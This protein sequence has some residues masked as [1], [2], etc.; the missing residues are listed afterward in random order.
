MGRIAAFVNVQN[1]LHPEKK[2]ECDVLVDT[3]TSHLVLPN[4]W[5][6]RLGDLT[7]IGTVEMETATQ[8]TVC[9]PVQ[10]QIEGFR[11]IFTEVLFIDMQPQDGRYEPL[12]GYIVL[13]QSQAA[14]D[15]LGR[16]LVHVKR[17]DL[18]QCIRRPPRRRA[19]SA[20]PALRGWPAP[21]PLKSKI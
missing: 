6:K 5:R 21:G 12:L 13:E 1:P 9:G 19:G 17:L 20:G 2:I 7:E 18:K 16:R 11:P 15:M 8:A 4:A 3:G 10:V 14:V